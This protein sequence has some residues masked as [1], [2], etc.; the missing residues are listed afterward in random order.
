MNL[1][2]YYFISLG[3]IIEQSA[4]RFD[5]RNRSKRITGEQNFCSDALSDE[6]VDDVDFCG[7]KT[8]GSDSSDEEFSISNSKQKKAKKQSPK[9]SAAKP[10]NINTKCKKNQITISPP[11]TLPYV[12]NKSANPLFPD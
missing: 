12:E 8:P 1:D 2:L 7:F 5:G 4:K 9:K 10:K 6:A 3:D 11:K